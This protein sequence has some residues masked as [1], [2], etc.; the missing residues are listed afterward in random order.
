MFQYLNIENVQKPF[1]LT[2]T[3]NSYDFCTNYEN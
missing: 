1:M 3:W 2:I